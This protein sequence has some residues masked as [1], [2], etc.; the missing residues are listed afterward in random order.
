VDALQLQ[1]GFLKDRFLREAL[2]PAV[3]QDEGLGNHPELESRCVRLE[4]QNKIL[5][6]MTLRLSQSLAEAVRPGVPKETSDLIPAI[7]GLDKQPIELAGRMSNRGTIH[8]QDHL[9]GELAAIQE[10]ISDVKLT[11][12]PQKQ[13]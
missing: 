7:G 5:K 9:L 12:P 2:A 13:V 3:K 6:A 11:T 8:R 4:M 10:L 1:V